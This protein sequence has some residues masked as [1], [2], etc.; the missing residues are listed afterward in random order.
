MLPHA[1]EIANIQVGTIIGKLNGV[2]PAQTPT[3]WRSEY[4]SMV[5][6]TFSL[7]SPFI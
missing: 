1:I 6:E 7:N 3:G 2:M 5:V 4:V